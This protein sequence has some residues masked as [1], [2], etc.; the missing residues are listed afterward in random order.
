MRQAIEENEIL[1]FEINITFGTKL[2]L[3][4]IKNYKPT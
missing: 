2:K 3:E 1:K 4:E